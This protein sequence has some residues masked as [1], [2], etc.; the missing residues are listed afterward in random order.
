MAFEPDPE[1]FMLIQENVKQ[2]QLT[3]VTVLNFAL[4]YA[5]GKAILFGNQKPGS[6][7]KV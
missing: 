4:D 3:N 5:A 2:N 7:T 6:L 1:A